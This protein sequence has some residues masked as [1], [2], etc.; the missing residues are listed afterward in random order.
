[1][2]IKKG[3]GVRKKHEGRVFVWGELNLP[4]PKTKWNKFIWKKGED[5]LFLSTHADLWWEERE[6]EVKDYYRW[7]PY[8]PTHFKKIPLSDLPDLV[9]WDLGIKPDPRAKVI[10]VT[11]GWATSCHEHMDLVE[12]HDIPPGTEVHVSVDI[13]PICGAVSGQIGDDL[14]PERAT[15]IDVRP[16]KYARAIYDF[17][18]F[19]R[20]WAG[21]SD[22][23]KD[24]GDQDD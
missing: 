9:L 18:G 21:I 11:A 3:I 20:Y 2:L 1:M 10:F 5:F 8:R 16:R 23:I 12:I 4:G 13:C 7:A 17:Y 6:R 14:P 24:G 22:H 15:L 19:W